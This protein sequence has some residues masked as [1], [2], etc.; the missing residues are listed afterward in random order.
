[1]SHLALG[2]NQSPWAF[3]LL[4]KFS[5][6]SQNMTK[7]RVE[8]AKGMPGNWNVKIAMQFS[9]HRETVTT[10]GKPAF[11]KIPQRLHMS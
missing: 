4:K 7:T 5:R 8:A 2:E 6:N 1:M 11:A 10:T 9:S 3:I